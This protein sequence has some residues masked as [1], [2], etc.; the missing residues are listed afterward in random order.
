[1]ITTYSTMALSAIVAAVAVTFAFVVFIIL[2]A[3]DIF[4]AGRLDSRE[5]P[6]LHAK[7]PYVGHLL[8]MVHHGSNFWTSIKLVSDTKPGLYQC[9]D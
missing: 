1:M 9:R 5:A 4:L 2:K 8:S 6:I 7:I 3:Y